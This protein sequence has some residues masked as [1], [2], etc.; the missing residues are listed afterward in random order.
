MIV[1]GGIHEVTYELNDL[2]IYDINTN[3]WYLVNEDDKNASQSGS[4]KNK[5]I[6][7]QSDAFKKQSVQLNLMNNPKLQSRISKD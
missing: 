3:S 5:A 2:H 4:P 6:M 1:F 7:Q